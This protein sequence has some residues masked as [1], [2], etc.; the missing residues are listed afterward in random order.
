MIRA[1]CLIVG[2]GISGLTAAQTLSQQGKRCLILEKS[3]GV[4]GRMATRRTADAVFDHGTQFFTARSQP[5]QQMASRWL[6]HGVAREWSRGFPD[7][8]GSLPEERHPRYCGVGGMTAV[9]KSL[10]VGLDVRRNTKIVAVRIEV[11]EWVL[12]SETGERFAG[13]HLLLTAP[14][15]QSLSLLEGCAYPIPAEKL[16]ALRSVR[17]DSCLAALLTLEG[18]SG[19]PKPGAVSFREGPIAWI[20]DNHQKGISPLA[21]AVTVHASPELS[22][23]LWSAPEEVA[24]REIRAASDRWLGSAIREAVLHRWRYSKPAFS[25][26]DA[27]L[28]L[29]GPPSLTFAGDAFG[30]PRVEGAALSGLIAA[31]LLS[32]YGRDV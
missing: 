22:L 19:I 14:V 7:P 10:A 18:A 5:F 25:P 23:D 20:A 9:P 17:Y 16:D 28:Y 26:F 8:E 1:D 2:A 11:G 32:G 3:R 24:L 29:A 12:T 27:P 21:T 15:P 4:G 30:A 13:A 6:Q 31:H